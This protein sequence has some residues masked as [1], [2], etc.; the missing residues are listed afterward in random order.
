[1]TFKDMGNIFKKICRWHGTSGIGAIELEGMEFHAFHGCLE[2]EKTEGN[3]FIVDF[4]AET[5]VRTAGRSDR[6]EDTLDYGAVYRI[7][8]K[9][10][11][12]RSDLIENAAWRIEEA[13]L[14]AFESRI[15]YMK[16]RVSKKN[17][18]VDGPCAWSRVTVEYGDKMLEPNG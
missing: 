12:K 8:A 6:L 1:M 2:K 3:T 4:Y 9:E 15:L 5:D 11:E 13:I 10:M 7:V 17:P 18:P 16:V 14:N